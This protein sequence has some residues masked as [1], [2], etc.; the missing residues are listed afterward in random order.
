MRF[1]T[2]FALISTLIPSFTLALPSPQNALSPLGPRSL[3]IYDHQERGTGEDLFTALIMGIAAAAGKDLASVFGVKP[4][5]CCDNVDW[6]CLINAGKSKDGHGF[7]ACYGPGTDEIYDFDVEVMKCIID[8]HYR[9]PYKCIDVKG[10]VCGNGA[11]AGSGIMK[12][13]LGWWGKGSSKA[14][15]VSDQDSKTLQ[16]AAETMRGVKINYAKPSN[17]AILLEVVSDT[18]DLLSLEISFTG[19]QGKEC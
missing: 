18:N 4:P 8:L 5:T 13:E 1:S 19:H 9:Q 11:G 10:S 16:A 14:N 12:G 2:V 17:G 3:N 15:L 7:Q 6:P